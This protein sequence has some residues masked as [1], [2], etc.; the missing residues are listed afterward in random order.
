MA[1]DAVQTQTKVDDYGNSYTTRI[2]NDNLTNEDFLTLL[3]EE[4]K[5]QDP[6]SP[7]DSNR[8]LDTQM[9][10]SNIQTNLE[11]AKSME[12]LQ[13]SYSLSALSTAANVIGKNIEDGNISD[14]GVNKAYTVRSVENTDG[15]V[16]V[17]AQEIL[18]L[19][20]QVLDQDGKVVN[21]DIKGNILD[22]AGN[23]TGHYIALKNPGEVIRDSDN[24]PIILDSE[25]EGVTQTDDYSFEMAGSVQAVYSDQLITIPFTSVTK[26]F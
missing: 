3:L 9:Q 1:V 13:A 11:L 20:D 24:K 8:M 5:H 22:S 15:E 17:R 10:M 16:F 14:S 12:S 4:M 19:E 7:M 23:A 25:G 26:I 21:Y 18:F 2:S 6:T